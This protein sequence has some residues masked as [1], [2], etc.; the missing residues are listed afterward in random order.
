MT[1]LHVYGMLDRGVATTRHHNKFAHL[2]V[3]EW[4]NVFI[5]NIQDNYTKV[6]KD[7]II[8]WMTGESF[9]R[10]K[11]TKHE[12]KT[13]TSLIPTICKNW[14]LIFLFAMVP[15][16]FLL[17]K[18]THQSITLSVVPTSHF[19]TVVCCFNTGYTTH[20]SVLSIRNLTNR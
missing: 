10:E 4:W 15:S 13:L 16:N 5:S 17:P 8:S 3:S 19:S 1:C 11:K 18:M 12:K 7:P 6:R 14:N 2:V 9:Y 20:Q